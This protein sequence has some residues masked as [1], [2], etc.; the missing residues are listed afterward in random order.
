MMR[1]YFARPIFTPAEREYNAKIERMI[2]ELGI[3]RPQWSVEPQDK[4]DRRSRAKRVFD[5]CMQ[6]IEPANALLAILTG[7]EVDDGTA[8]EMGIF[9]ALMEQQTARK[10]IIGLLDDWR[11]DVQSEHVQ[12]KGLNQL[13][14][15]CIH[16]GG[17][18]MQTPEAAMSRLRQWRDEI[19]SADMP[20]GQLTMPTSERADSLSAQA[21]L[22]FQ[23]YFAAPQYTPYARAFVADC[24]QQLRGLGVQVYVPR[25]RASCHPQ[26]PEPQEVFERDYTQLKRSQAM[27]ALLDG[28]QPDDAVA[29][30]IGL[31][32]GLALED[33]SK[34]GILGYMTDARGVRR[35]NQGYGCNHFPVGVIE[36]RGYVTHQFGRILDQVNHW[37][38]DPASA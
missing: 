21:D 33:S 3:D 34:R 37:C 30:E 17:E 23:V 8:C 10:G 7:T 16:S 35:A 4:S 24:A 5:S 15:G 19:E 14:L 32:Y 11:T 29:L 9:Y 12:G 38:T 31:F 28:A 13:L 25:A 1:V 26:L 2:D 36:E 27:V 18:L 22:P 20:S 6:G